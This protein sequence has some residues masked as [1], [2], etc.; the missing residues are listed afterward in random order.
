VWTTTLGTI[1]GTG[2]FTAPTRAGTATVTAT[3]GTLT[4]T[5]SVTVPAPKPRVASVETKRVAG[6]LL[7]TVTVKPAARVRIVLRVRRGSS[8]VAVVRTVTTRRGTFTWRS[9]RPLPRGH[10]VASAA[11]R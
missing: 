7:A 2:L 10:Y 3:A 6:H 5:A 11:L 8:I 4:A 1:D 9:R